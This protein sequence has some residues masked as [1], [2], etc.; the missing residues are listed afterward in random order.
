MNH[1]GPYV[2]AFFLLAFVGRGVRG[3]RA[4]LTRKQRELI[5]TTTC[6]ELGTTR[7]VRR[8]HTLHTCHARS[9]SNL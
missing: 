2:F 1:K 7:Q 6:L 4:V 9:G 5:E 3:L 8:L